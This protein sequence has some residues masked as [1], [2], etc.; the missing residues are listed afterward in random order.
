MLSLGVDIGGTKIETLVLNEQGEEIHRKRY[1]TEKSSLASFTDRIMDIIR[2]TQD[3]VKEKFSIGICIPGASE[4]ST[5]FIKN[6]NI[7]VL[8]NQP[9]SEILEKCCGQ[10]IAL[11]NDANCFTLSEAIDGAGQGYS[12]VFGLTL[13]TGCGGGI[14][15]NQKVHSGQNS[16]AGE[17]GHNSL[18]RYS[19][20]KDG[21]EIMC[22]CGQKNCIETFISGTGL[23][24]RFNER[25]QTKLT[26]PQIFAAYDRKEESACRHVDLFLDQLARSLSDVVN[27]LD[28]DIFVIGGG[29]S[30]LPLL[31]DN[32]QE[33]IG[34]YVFGKSFT[35][36]VI[37][38]R[39]GGSSGVRG[40]AWLGRN[41]YAQSKLSGEKAFSRI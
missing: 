20:E 11:S 39:H 27:I 32:L 15:I 16:C 19:P 10:P 12:V 9:F 34:A 22:Y 33:R 17:W 7:L 23:A 2:D 4:A 5:G 38:A 21:G 18:P 36:P 25:F 1:E 29:L 31:Y 24:T 14:V 41:Q 3:S 8:N 6:S 28:P 35:T 26:A 13:G 37:A 30:S 40:A